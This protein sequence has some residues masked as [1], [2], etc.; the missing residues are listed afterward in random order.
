[1]DEFGYDGPSVTCSNCDMEFDVIWN[2]NPLYDHIEYCPF[3]GVEL[4]E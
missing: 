3:C 2:R 4:N 1:M